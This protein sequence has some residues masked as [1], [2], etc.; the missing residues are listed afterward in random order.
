MILFHEVGDLESQTTRNKV[1]TRAHTD[2]ISS[3]IRVKR[4]G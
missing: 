4:V 3:R 1:Q 2:A